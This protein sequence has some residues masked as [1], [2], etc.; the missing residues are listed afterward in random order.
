MFVCFLVS[1]SELAQGWLYIRVVS[2]CLTRRMA[3]KRTK[4]AAITLGSRC[5]SRTSL[6]HP[7]SHLQNAC[8]EDS[9]QKQ[10][11]KTR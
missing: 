1:G 7:T 11:L 10:L 5:K 8:Q 6:E 2:P 4:L 9:A 3:T